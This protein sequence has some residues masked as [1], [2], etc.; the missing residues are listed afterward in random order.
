[1]KDLVFM[2]EARTLD[3][4]LA[5]SIPLPDGGALLPDG[6]LFADDPGRLAFRILDRHGNRTGRHLCSDNRI[7]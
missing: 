3:E 4:L 1:M 2:K 6:E 5:R 7:V